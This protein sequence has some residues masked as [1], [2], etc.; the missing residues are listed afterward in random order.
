MFE[1]LG[2]PADVDQS[3]KANLGDNRTE[4]AGSSGDTVTSGSI[5]SGEDLARNDKGC[6]VRAEVLE[7][8]GHAVEEH[9]R[10]FPTGRRF[11]FVVSETHDAE[12]DSEEG[13]T[14]KLDRLATPGVDEEEGGV[15]TGDETADSEDKVTDSDIVEG[16]L[17]VNLLHRAG[18]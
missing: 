10:L 2:G 13:E 14:H 7:E 1:E 16:L 15:V 5:A 9:E 17:N 8:V 18:G 11:K 6:G 12:D 3:R 4:L